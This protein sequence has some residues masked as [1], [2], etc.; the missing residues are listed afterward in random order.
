MVELDLLARWEGA[1]RGEKLMTGQTQ[2]DMH[3]CSISSLAR[4]RQAPG[5]RRGNLSSYMIL[6]MLFLSLQAYTELVKIKGKQYAKT[7]SRG[8]KAG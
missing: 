4:T 8:K 5:I 6:L 1:A 7:T 2:S 3:W